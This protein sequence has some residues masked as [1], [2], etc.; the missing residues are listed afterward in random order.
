MVKLEDVNLSRLST[1]RVGGKGK[2]YFKVFNYKELREALRGEK[3]FILGGGS[4]SVFGNFSGRIIDLKGLRKFKVFEEKEGLRVICGAGLPLK[5]LVS[6]AL[7]ENLKG[8]YRLYGFPATVG[9]AVAM[10]SSAFGY[11]ISEDLRKVLVMDWEGN[12]K[13]FKREELKFSYRKSP[14][15]REGVVVEAEFLFKRAGESV[16]EDFLKVREKRR[17]SQPLGERSCGST[18]KNP[19]GFF[20]G[21]L[22]EEAGLRGFRLGSLAFSRKHANFL[23]NLGGGTYYE[24]LKILEVAKERVFKLFGV[25]LEEEIVLVDDLYLGAVR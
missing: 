19:K 17:K 8:I 15:P 11:E 14:F 24:L 9:G 22:L 21:K 16:R 4:N 10:N 7:R 3:I 13:E 25:E 1:L 18:F 12:L 6:L 20:A 5:E 23:I 2:E